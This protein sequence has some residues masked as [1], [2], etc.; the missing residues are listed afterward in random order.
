MKKISSKI[1]RSKLDNWVSRVGTGRYQPSNYVDDIDTTFS[2]S[3]NFGIQQV[4]T[5]I[6]QFIDILLKQKIA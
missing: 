3:E 2:L 1:I 6:Y 5:E 4:R